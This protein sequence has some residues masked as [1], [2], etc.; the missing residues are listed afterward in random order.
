MAPSFAPDRYTHFFYRKDF[1]DGVFPGKMSQYNN[2]H[3]GGL[4]FSNN[5]YVPMKEEIEQCVPDTSIYSRY[6]N[7]FIENYDPNML[8]WKNI[9][10]GVH[11]RLSLNGQDPWKNFERQIAP[12]ARGR[13]FF[14]HDYNLNNITNA[15]E[16]IHYIFNKYK[17]GET[18]TSL[19]VK[20][21]ILCSDVSSLIKWFDFIFATTNYKLQYNNL[22]TDEEL[23][24]I[25]E[26][27]TESQSK[28][29]YYNPFPNASNKNDFSEEDL[30]YLFKQV[31]FLYTNRKQ[32][33]LICNDSFAI[34]DEIKKMFYLFSGY[35][36]SESK[37]HIHT[38]FF[39][40]IKQF[41]NQRL[42][43]KKIMTVPETREVFY[44]VQKHYPELFKL[45]YEAGAVS[46]KGGEL[47]ID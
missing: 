16:I 13:T 21:P 10:Y 31:I 37:Q 9:N 25:T 44:Y 8:S 45:F 27:M 19:C 30:I 35:C 46:Y 12:T 24:F 29:I 20:F 43:G 33:S 7:I 42:Y 36:R 41:K 47:V 4:A 39:Y 26:N 17:L 18:K 11:L 22:L 5:K 3:F 14:L 1:Y 15:A 40:Y 2:L 6:K 28:K 34:P 38:S 32:F 23:I